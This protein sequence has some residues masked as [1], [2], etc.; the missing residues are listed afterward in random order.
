MSMKNIYVWIRITTLCVI[1]TVIS[2]I[3]LFAYDAWI[4][5]YMPDGSRLSIKDM[6]YHTLISWVF[7]V[8]QLWFV[9][10]F[11]KEGLTV[12]SPVQLVIF[13]FMWTFI[14]QLVVNKLVFNNP[15]SI[16]DYIGMACI[17]LGIVI[18][19]TKLIG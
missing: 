1:A 19:K 7:L 4:G 11:I 16:A 10:L 14:I 15:N 9:V 3:S 8:V 6:I 5:Q 13:V 12:M 17:I 18:S 2:Q